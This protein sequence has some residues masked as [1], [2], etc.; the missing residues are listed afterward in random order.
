MSSQYDIHAAKEAPA[1][2]LIRE[3][4][5]LETADSDTLRQIARAR[6]LTRQYFDSDYAD[7]EKRTAILKELLGGMGENVA[8]DTPFHCDYGKNIFLGND[9]VINMNCTFVDN[10]P[11]R[12][13]DRVLIASNVQIYTSS[14]PVLPQERL[15]PDWKKEC[16]TTFFRTYARP[17][18]IE[19]R[20]WIGGGS[21][22]LPGVTI[23]ENSVIGAGSVVNRSIPPNC[24][25][26]GNPCR[27]IRQ[28]GSD[29]LEG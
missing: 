7:I 3:W 10:K 5:F 1:P 4:D 12:I 29:C 22:L 9:V 28:F 18:V 2:G 24:V 23:G 21:I 15:V 17:V 8:I 20:V 27:V 16:R 25:A 26:V 11:I 6:E 14:H 19:D 13:G